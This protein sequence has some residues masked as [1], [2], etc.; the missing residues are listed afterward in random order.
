VLE[1][2]VVIDSNAM[3]N[4]IVKQD[5]SSLLFNVTHNLEP[6][7]N[8]LLINKN[9][10][11]EWVLFV[12]VIVFVVLAWVRIYHT[13][14][15]KML[16]KAFVSQ[17][18]V[19]HLL[20]ESDSLM[21]GLSLA[22]NFVFF[23]VISLFLYLI[24]TYYNVYV[25]LTEVINPFFVFFGVLI[26]LYQGKALVLWILGIVF[27][28]REH[29]YKYIFNVFLCN[30]ILGILLLPVVVGVSYL[31]N[32]ELYLIYTGFVLIIAVYFFRIY[33]GV[34]ICIREANVSQYYIFLYLCTLEFLPFVVITRFV[35][36]NL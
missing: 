10:Y 5:L 36:T 8:G 24:V 3:T 35:S 7:S 25:P 34:V 30:K 18:Y 33:R 1:D 23:T 11:P 27:N 4:S 22:L 31:K 26:L 17:M 6:G 13:K 32:G 15:A 21:I 14:R 12:F 2:S 19:Q 16:I 28:Q 9:N 20:R 29:F